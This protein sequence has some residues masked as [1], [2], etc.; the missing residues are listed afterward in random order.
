MGFFLKTSRRDELKLVLCCCWTSY[1]FIIRTINGRPLIIDVVNITKVFV[2]G[3][4]YIINIYMKSVATSTQN[5]FR[6]QP[7]QTPTMI[8]SRI[9]NQANHKSKFILHIFTLRCVYCVISLFLCAL[10]NSSK[11]FTQRSFSLFLWFLTIWCR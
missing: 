6:N 2:K 10:S 11:L 8:K 9:F 5:G 7:T 4:L 3:F 1:N